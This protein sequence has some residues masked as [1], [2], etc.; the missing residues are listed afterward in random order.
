MASTYLEAVISASP[1]VLV[2]LSEWCGRCVVVV[3]LIVEIVLVEGQIGS[4]C[5]VHV[6]TI[7][8]KLYFAFFELFSSE[9]FNLQQ[10]HQ[11]STL[12]PVRFTDALEEE[13]LSDDVLVS[14]AFG[15]HVTACYASVLMKVR[16]PHLPHPNLFHD[17]IICD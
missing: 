3:E 7:W 6:T 4:M 2:C 16:T 13:H 8:S 12:T 14:L 1:I 5:V 10:H 11:H 9:L 15:T 17:A